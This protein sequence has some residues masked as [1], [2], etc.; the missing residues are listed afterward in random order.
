MKVLGEFVW[1][2]HDDTDEFFLVLEGDL[3][4]ELADRDPV[5]LAPGEFFIVPK[6]VPHRPV[7]EQEC[8]VVLLEPAGTVN[9]G[10]AETSE[11][12]SDPAWL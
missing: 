12:T 8:E 11:M 7:A 9:T 10:D 4:I 1:H 5:I 2:Q 3:T 6:G